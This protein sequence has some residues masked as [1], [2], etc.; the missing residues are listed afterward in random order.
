M[1]V[2]KLREEVEITLHPARS[3][4]AKGEMD[5]V[6]GVLR[7]ILPVWSKKMAARLDEWSRE[8]FDASRR[9]RLDWAVRKVIEPGETYAELEEELGR[10]R[11]KGIWGR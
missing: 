8:K 5:R 6:Q 2:G 4:L 10:R 7:E 11:M 1:T 9:G 3:L